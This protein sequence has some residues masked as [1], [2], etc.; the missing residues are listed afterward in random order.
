MF[1][2]I[3]VL[4]KQGLKIDAKIIE[5]IDEIFLNS[6]IKIV[7]FN[8][9]KKEDLVDSDLIITL[10]GDGTFIKAANLM[11]NSLIIGVN[12]EPEFSEG[13][14]TGLNVS[15]IH[16]LREIAEG[17][18]EVIKRHRAMVKLNGERL[19][20]HALNE[21][22]VG[23]LSQFHSSR[24]KIKFRGIEE[25]HRSSGVI[26]ST[27]TG[28]Q[29][30]FYSAGGEI[31]EYDEEKLKFIVREPYFGKRIFKPKILNGEIKKGINLVIESRRDSG[32][33][34]AINDST[35]KFNTGDVVEITISDKPIR[36]IKLK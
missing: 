4:I 13:A 15:D 31:F 34:I 21:V 35:Y 17:K 16:R 10:G 25:E 12:A 20:E 3:I 6:N 18:Y 36:V 19:E 32:G 33:I 8:D 24:Y 26:V 28:S 5:K 22:Y 11:D 29:A 7:S 23:A 14:L 9:L 2:K 27:G 30:W 1:N